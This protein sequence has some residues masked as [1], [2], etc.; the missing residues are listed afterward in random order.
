[1]R[2]RL[3]SQEQHHDPVPTVHVQEMLRGRRWPR[4]W[5]CSRSACTRRRSR[6]AP[7]PKS[8]AGTNP[9]K[10]NIMFTLDD[11][12]S[13]AWDTLPDYL[14]E[15]APLLA[16]NRRRVGNCAMSSLGPDWRPVRSDAHQSAVPQQDFNQHLLRSV[17]HLRRRAVAPDGT[18][19]PCEGCDTGCTGH[20][21]VSTATDLP[22][23]RAQHGDDQSRPLA[24]PTRSFCWKPH[25]PTPADFGTRR[26]PTGSVA[27]S[28][29]WRYTGCCH[30]PANVHR[31][32]RVA[33]RVQLSK[34]RNADMREHRDVNACVF[35]TRQLVTGNPYYY[36]IAR[37]VL[38][39]PDA[40]A[41]DGS[42]GACTPTLRT[43]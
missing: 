36:T 20:G 37:S 29:A 27:D 5:R 43:A 24:F 2:D 23:I 17:G 19:L 41:G 13:M 7:S 22:D 34:R 30:R 1:M 11:S 16:A 8:A 38:F 10:P 12:A 28:T 33:R 35:G 9:V 18:D 26:R 4:R 14:E 15:A 6:R 32:P 3:H 31:L 39:E 21:R 40:T 42:A 25:R